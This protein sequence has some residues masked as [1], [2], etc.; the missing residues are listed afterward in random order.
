MAP[1]ERS[2]GDGPEPLAA[3]VGGVVAA[4]VL[5][6]LVGIVIGTLTFVVRIAV[7][8]A[9]VVAGFWVWGKISGD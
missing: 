2:D 4:L 5:T 9:L 8:V 1:I 6:W 7:L 3:I